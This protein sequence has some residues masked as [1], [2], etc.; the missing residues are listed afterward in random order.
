MAEDGEKLPLRRLEGAVQKFIKV[1][2]PTDLE[3]LKKHQINIEKYQRCSLWEKLH[4]EQI[5]AGRTVQ[6]LRAN[7]REMEK[8]CQ[9]V[10]K[11]DA[12]ALEKM[13]NP[14]KEQASAATVEFLKLHAESEKE[15]TRQA[16]AQEA[17]QPSS[18]A[19][20]MTV[21]GPFPND[22]TEGEMQS[23]AMQVQLPLPEIPQDQ[24]AAESWEML[25][26]DLIELNTLINEF[27]QL[28]HSQQEK[29]DSIEDHVNTAAA[30]VEEG[31][32]NLGKAAKYKLA[33]L[34][35]AGALIGG[36]VG[37]PIGLLAGF[38]VA[39]VAAAVSGGVLGF[40][41]GKLIQ[42]K[43]EQTVEENMKKLST[44]CPNLKS[45]THKKAS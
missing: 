22:R 42:R 45:Q 16:S 26:E 28:V 12:T 38:K 25:E 15:L 19:R 44:S 31:T 10:R 7:M 3:R 13:I 11:E 24:E 40:T 36:V 37:G 35:V 6:Q 23:L 39:G 1:V 5:N 43:R 32:K 29:I 4:Q 9:R 33:V 34:P 14:V 27:S 30:N 17:L 21:E 8:L 18:L 41:G 2:I 20:S